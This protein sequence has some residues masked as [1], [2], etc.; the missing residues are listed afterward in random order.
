MLLI[1]VF[2][3]ETS[4][5]TSSHSK[6]FEGSLDRDLLK[7]KAHLHACLR[8]LHHPG[9]L[10]LARLPLPRE[11]ELFV[12]VCVLFLGDRVFFLCFCLGPQALRRVPVLFCS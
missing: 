11:G 7:I 4:A 10:P 8:G 12:C 9:V 3:T 5:K 2:L 6:S 1:V